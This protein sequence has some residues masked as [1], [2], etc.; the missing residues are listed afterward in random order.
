MR[1]AGFLYERVYGRSRV[2]SL[3][4]LL[5]RQFRPMPP[6]PLRRDSLLVTAPEWF[7]SRARKGMR[8]MQRL[9][10]A[11]EAAAQR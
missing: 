5:Q 4:V 10:A 3:S 8:M 6:L 1:A 2:P 11:E 7:D 9:M